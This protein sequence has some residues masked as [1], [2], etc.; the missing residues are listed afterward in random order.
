MCMKNDI[1][2]REAEIADVDSICVLLADAFA[3]YRGYYSAEAYDLTV[4]SRATMMNRILDSEFDVIVALHDN[5]VGG[6]ATLNAA[7]PGIMYLRSMA[8][9]RS[10]QGRGIGYALLQQCE[11]RARSRKC[12]II[13]LE[14]FEPLKMAISLYRRMGY[15]R[16]GAARDYAG[17]EVF[18]MQK[19]IKMP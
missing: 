9:S 16:T 18:E 4:C 2:I 1:M 13:S 14:C 11:D 5:R 6:T 19:M 8:V 15:K 17:I 7:K 12:G 3:P 10:M